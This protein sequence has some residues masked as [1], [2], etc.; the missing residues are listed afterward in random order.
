M[1][2]VSKDFLRFEKDYFK[3]LGPNTDE[4]KENALKRLLEKP[5][6]PEFKPFPQTE[7]VDFH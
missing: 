6:K 5:K 4:T 7:S 3:D 2:K 1:K